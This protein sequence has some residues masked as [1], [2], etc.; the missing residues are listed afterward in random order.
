MKKILLFIAILTFSAAAS[1]QESFSFSNADKYTFGK[2]SKE[3]LLRNDY[4]LSAPADA[5]V[6][7]EYVRIMPSMLDI[8]A[9]I[10]RGRLSPMILR[11]VVA[12]KIKILTDNGVANSKISI[13]LKYNSATDCENSEAY[14]VRAY[15]YTLKNDKIVKKILKPAN[16]TRREFADGSACLEFEIPNVKKGSIIE[17]GYTKAIITQNL[18]YTRTMQENLPK[19][20]SQY[21]V[22]LNTQHAD[23]F[24][25]ATLNDNTTYIESDNLRFN[26]TQSYARGTHAAEL[27]QQI[28]SNWSGPR[29]KKRETHNDKFIS[30]IYQ[31]SNYSAI[32]SGAGVVITV[33]IDK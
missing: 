28:T 21:M 1:A 23:L 13:P 18:Q 12:R 17:Y 26:Y 6:L 19:L 10:N 30:K 22:V 8:E 14:S 4:T 11:E 27:H 33:K 25:I 9:F 32:E 7:D 3:D 15:S 29:G 2:I 5:I 24:D 31:A 20:K 16:I